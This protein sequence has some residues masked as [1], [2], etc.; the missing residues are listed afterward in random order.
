MDEEGHLI[1]PTGPGD[2]RGVPSPA[3]G[4]QPPPDPTRRPDQRPAAPVPGRPAPPAA[5][6]DFLDRA[7][8]REEDE[9]Q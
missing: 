3:E 2:R 6:D 7:T 4:E 5:S 9:A 8:G 1:E